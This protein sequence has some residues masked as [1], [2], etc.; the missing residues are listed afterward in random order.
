MNTGGVSTIE[1]ATAATSGLASLGGED[2]AAGPRTRAARTRTR[3]SARARTRAAS[4]PGDRARTPG[5]ARSRTTSLSAIVPSTMPAIGSG[6]AADQPEVDLRADRDEEQAEQQPLE[7]LDVGLEL[8]AVLAVGEHHA[9]E[10]R[11]ERGRQPDLLHEQR[12]ADHDQQRGGGER[13][14]QPGR[15][16]GTGT[17]GGRRTARSRSPRPP[18]RAPSAPDSQAG[19]PASEVTSVTRVAT[20]TPS[21]GNTARIGITAM[22]WNSSTENARLAAR[23]LEQAALGERRQ[24]DR[25]RRHRERQ[26]DRDRGLA[27]RRRARARARR[28]PPRS[29]RPAAPPRPRIGR[30]SCHSSAGRSSS[31]TRNSI[32]T[33]PNSAKCITLWPSVPTSPSTHGPI[34]DAARS[35]SR[36][37]R[38][39]RAASRS[40]RTPRPPA[41]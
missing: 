25:G 40:A 13:L 17:A 26:A 28:R 21:S 10:E 4:A 23:R 41:R 8:V 14:A 38:R 1:I 11:A 31:P 24:H 6:L 33:T 36:A 7:R 5:R 16:R 34:D 9:G 39:A 18:R 35:G 22:S 3:R 29:A 32:I 15:R 27:T 2:A 12:D 37:P 19:R 30:R 20:A